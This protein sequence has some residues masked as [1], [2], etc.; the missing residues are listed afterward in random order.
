MKRLR[1]ASA[2][3][4]LETAATP[5]ISRA[6]AR[7]ATQPTANAILEAA[8]PIFARD[9]FDGASIPAIARA[10][11][12]GH[13]LVHYHFGSKEKLWHAAADHAFGELVESIDAVDQHAG[14]LEPV[15]ALELLCRTFAQFTASHPMHTLIVLNE[16]RAG[17][18]R[19]DWLVERYLRPLH[20]RLDRAIEAAVA[21]GRIR[22][23]PAVHL[24]GIAI[25]ATVHFFGA[26]P[27]AERLYDVDVRDADVIET[28]TRWVLEILMNG[29]AITPAAASSAP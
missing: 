7:L 2:S 13:P 15:A 29:L 5:E 17:G 25:G 12:I 16:V 4:R 27:L 24:A 6:P 18:Q 10:V 3:G 11:S 28:H 9:G 21:T 20:A 19:F 23:I 14:T 26:G 22:P 8:L 1:S